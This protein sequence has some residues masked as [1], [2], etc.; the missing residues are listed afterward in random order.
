[1]QKHLVKQKQ[2]NNNKRQSRRFFAVVCQLLFSGEY[3]WNHNNIKCSP[4]KTEYHRYFM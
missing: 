2:Q 1:M 3:S 4:L